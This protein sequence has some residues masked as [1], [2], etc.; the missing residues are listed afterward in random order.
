[1]GTM[2]YR[3]ERDYVGIVFPYSLLAPSKKTRPSGLRF[4]GFRALAF[5]L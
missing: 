3:N 5:G 2:F 1:M 4:T